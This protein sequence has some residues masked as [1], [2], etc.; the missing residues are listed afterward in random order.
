[1]NTKLN[2]ALMVVTTFLIA[3]ACSPEMSSQPILDPAQPE[4]LSP[5]GSWSTGN[6][7][8]VL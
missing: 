6:R 2:L 3:T 1:M 8:G 7:E 5:C 4:E